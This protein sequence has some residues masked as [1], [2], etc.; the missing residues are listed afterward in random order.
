MLL[1]RMV[2]S[3]DWEAIKSIY[4]EG[5]LTGNATFETKAPSKE[6]WYS[7]HNL[8]F[9]LVCLNDDEVLGWASLSPVSSRC[10]YAGVAENSIYVRQNVRGRGVGHLLL[11]KLVE[12]SENNGFWT[13]Q[14]GIFPE[15]KASIALHS[16]HG[17]RE[18]GLRKRVGKMNGVWRD[19]L[20]ME[21]RSEVVGID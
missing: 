15:N 11:G 12:L 19:V 17:F 9:S 4:E 3:E 6:Q 7:S 1:T 10:V 21:R 14:T 2:S 16:K 20:F 13:I 5:I 18:I 8:E